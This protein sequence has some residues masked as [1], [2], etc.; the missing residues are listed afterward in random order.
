MA[1]SLYVAGGA[2]HV[3]HSH[4]PLFMRKP[5]NIDTMH[6]REHTIVPTDKGVIRHQRFPYSLTEFNGS[7][8]IKRTAGV[9]HSLRAKVHTPEQMTTY[10]HD[11][12]V[13]YGKKNRM[14]ET[15][16][17][18]SRGGRDTFRSAA[19]SKLSPLG[20]AIAGLQH[21]AEL[22]SKAHGHA[23]LRAEVPWS[24]T[25]NDYG[26]ISSP[27]DPP[28]SARSARLGTGS[29]QRQAMPKTPRAERR[30]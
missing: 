28:Q 8:E 20:P 22:G 9:K 19:K 10:E 14:A 6:L 7:L 21:A 18:S 23:H 24:T 15:M 25:A 2:H 4:S 17:G 1:G 3:S 29:S 5:E 11:F 27:R 13:I 12:D 16:P 26:G 30:H